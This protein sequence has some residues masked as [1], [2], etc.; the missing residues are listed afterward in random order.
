LRGRPPGD[1]P[2]AFLSLDLEA[3]KNRQVA[4]C[5]PKKAKVE[6][7]PLEYPQILVKTP[8]SKGLA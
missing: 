5:G 6:D 2:E 1:I 3:K 8:F 7:E 4:K